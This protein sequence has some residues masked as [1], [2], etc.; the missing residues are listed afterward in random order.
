MRRILIPVFIALMLLIATPTGDAVPVG[1]QFDEGLNLRPSKSQSLADAGGIGDDV[2][3]VAFMSRS[4]SGLSTLVLNS[5]SDVSTHYG[6]LNLNSYEVP[7]WTLFNITLNAESMNAVPER[8]SLG[9]TSST[10]PGHYIE[11][12]N[13]SG[14]VTDNLYQAF[15][16]MPHD[17]KLENY[18]FTYQMPQY[19]PSLGN[20]TLGIRSD[21]MD[22]L[23]NT[24]SWITPF[25]ENLFPTDITHDTSGDG[26]ILNASTYY[27]VIIDG[28]KLAGLDIGGGIW[29]FSL[30]RWAATGL[31]QNLETGYYLRGDGW[32]Q[33]TGLNREEAMLNYTYTPWN[34]TSNSQ[35]VYS[36]PDEISL[37]GNS[38]PF[39]GN[40]WSFESVN[41][42]TA[43]SF[44]SNQSAEINYNI[45]L[46]YMRNLAT[47]ASWYASSSGASIDWNATTTLAYPVLSGVTGQYLDVP[48]QSGW[49]ATGL[50]NSTTPSINYGNHSSD[51]HVTHCSNM[52]NGTWTLTFTAH[53]YVTQIETQNSLDS[54]V[55]GSKVNITVDMDI[56]S[57]V[58]DEFNLEANTGDTNLTVHYGMSRVYAPPDASVV[59]GQTQYLWDIDSTTSNNGTYVIEIFWTNGT[60]AGYLTKS[61]FVYF[62]TTFSSNDVSISAYTDDTFD[63]RVDYN[64]TFTPKSL[65]GTYASVTYTFNAV[66]NASLTDLLNGTWTAIVSTAGMAAGSYS[67]DIYAEAYGAENHTLNIPV[68]LTYETL[69]VSW[70]WSDPYQNNISY[71]QSTNL[72]V[73]YNISSGSGI[74]GAT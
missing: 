1:L 44:A 31:F 26:A 50:Y 2:G 3:S 70:S 51:S 57:T 7:G 29:V 61:V 28:S 43:I 8:E 16:N 6:L 25:E 60:E 23:T 58:K 46:Q 17:G 72:T 33:Y 37:S 56:I 5:Y 38:T 67:I 11:I 12:L 54:S 69:P 73:F 36:S 59:A 10:E 18:T 52:T 62:P 9:V 27:Y 21:F 63:I 20:A 24:S 40:I 13:N 42:I 74:S 53:N 19:Y 30:L 4:F 35:V 66:V 45:T 64:E 22:P 48:K 15:Y 65:N 41:N 49:T 71:F 32:Y 55:V 34:T 68:E 47:S 39:T 14:T